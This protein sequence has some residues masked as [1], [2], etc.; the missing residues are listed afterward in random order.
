MKRYNVTFKKISDYNEQIRFSW[1]KSFLLYSDI[2]KEDAEKKAKELLEEYMDNVISRSMYHRSA[3]YATYEVDSIKLSK[4]KEKFDSKVKSFSTKKKYVKSPMCS[5]RILTKFA[6]E[7]PKLH[8]LIL[9]HRNTKDETKLEILSL[10]LKSNEWTLRAEAAEHEL[11][12]ID[13]LETL[14]VDR[15]SSVRKYAIKSYKNRVKLSDEAIGVLNVTYGNHDPF[16][17]DIMKMLESI[18]DIKEEK[19]KTYKRG[20]AWGLGTP[21]IYT[22]IYYATATCPRTLKKIIFY[23]E[24]TNDD[25]TIYYNESHRYANTFIH[26]LVMEVRDLDFKGFL[27]YAKDFLK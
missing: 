7:E 16:N 24:D 2:G 3:G 12:P 9:K 8:R 13:N 6:K 18:L 14:C 1:R 15:D 5:T 20:G 25:L 23:K 17:I 19:E 26:Q 10:F 4:V 11:L 22:Y 27:E 21:S